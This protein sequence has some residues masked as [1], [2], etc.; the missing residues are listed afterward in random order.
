[1]TTKRKKGG[2]PNWYKGMPSPNPTGLAKSDRAQWKAFKKL[3]RDSAEDAMRVLVGIMHDVAAK[4]GDR[5]S[6]AKVVVA[7]GWGNPGPQEVP[8]EEA[9]NMDA[10]G[11]EERIELY[12]RAIRAEEAR[13]A[14]RESVH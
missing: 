6:A 10:K 1:M 12:R 2:N 8:A 11:S 4:E 9:V 5:I 13:I 14:Q 3:C 7:Y